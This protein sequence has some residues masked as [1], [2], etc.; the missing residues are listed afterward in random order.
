MID[1]Y[2]GK[3]TEILEYIGLPHIIADQI[4]KGVVKLAF[5]LLDYNYE[6]A[7]PYTPPRYLEELHGI[8]D[9][10]NGLA[11]FD[12]LRRVNFIPEI[13]KAACSIVGAWGPATEGGKLYHLRALDWDSHAPVSNYPSIVIYDSSEPNSN[14]FANIGFLG[15]IGI[16]TGVSKN[17]ITMGE[18]VLYENDDSKYPVE[19]ETTYI[20]KPW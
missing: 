5:Y 3:V 10:S 16:L 2:A 14:E 1:Y 17:G 7:A 13:I 15:M 8:H 18:K 12:L 4:T 19:L 20:G 9:G 6:L 11:D